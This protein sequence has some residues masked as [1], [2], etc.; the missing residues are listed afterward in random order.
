MPGLGMTE[1]LL[2][3]VVIVLIFGASRLP[4]LGQ[5]TTFG[6]PVRFAAGSPGAE[7]VHL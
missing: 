7:G 4:E 6:D 1:I 2:V 5:P 3:F